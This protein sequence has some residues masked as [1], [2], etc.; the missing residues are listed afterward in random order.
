[1]LAAHFWA[2]SLGLAMPAEGDSLLRSVSGEPTPMTPDV[3]R[4]GDARRDENKGFKGRVDSG[5]SNGGNGGS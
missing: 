1:M 4:L 5:G 3:T 2:V